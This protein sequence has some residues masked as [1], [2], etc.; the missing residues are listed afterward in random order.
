MTN[1]F[2]L[3]RKSPKSD[4]NIFDKELRDILIL[5]LDNISIEPMATETSGPMSAPGDSE[6]EKFTNVNIIRLERA[7]E[8]IIG[9]MAVLDITPGN[10][11][12]HDK[13][14]LFT[15]LQ[16][17]HA[18]L[19]AERKKIMPGGPIK[20]VYV[21]AINVLPGF[22]H[23]GEN[24]Y[25]EPGLDRLNDCLSKL[26]GA[27]T[28]SVRYKDQIMGINTADSKDQM[29]LL[30]RLIEKE[31]R[32]IKNNP[33]PEQP[34]FYFPDPEH[35]RGYITERLKLL[36]KYEK[37]LSEAP[38]EA[39]TN[40]YA[41]P[42]ALPDLPANNTDTTYDNGE[43]GPVHV[44]ED[45]F[46]H[47]NTGPVPSPVYVQPTVTPAVGKE[48]GDATDNGP[49]YDIPKDDSI[50]IPEASSH[51]AT[52]PSTTNTAENPLENFNNNK[53]Y[54]VGRIT[55]RMNKLDSSKEEEKEKFKALIIKVKNLNPDESLTSRLGNN[56]NTSNSAYDKTFNLL[57]KA[58]EKFD[59][60]NSVKNLF[61]GINEDK[62]KRIGKEIQE[63][64]HAFKSK[65]KKDGP[66]P[67]AKPPGNRP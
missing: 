4:K 22:Y 65:E 55:D 48:R 43:D 59:N 28:G 40:A 67:P 37:I 38:V 9:K 8:E 33:S 66:K 30:L 49:L 11:Y 16:K 10:D 34:G 58:A 31:I 51:P 60:N 3:F 32:E 24:A 46:E 36:K 63:K 56:K 23:T 62:T 6:I 15:S 2:D 25:N 14:E 27:E 41:V 18:E 52:L 5:A 12:E 39:V 54:I 50:V 45:L 13:E 42:S 61:E 64:L 17:I 20:E 47:K 1:F 29:G 35:H 19:N 21:D 53:A 44:Y 57:K 7:A 26:Y